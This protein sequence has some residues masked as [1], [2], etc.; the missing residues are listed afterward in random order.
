M[1]HIYDGKSCQQIVIAL[2]PIPTRLCYLVSVPGDS[3]DPLRLNNQ[4]VPEAY[5]FFYGKLFAHR[6]RIL[7]FSLLIQRSSDHSRLYLA[8]RLQVNF[9]AIIKI[10]NTL[11]FISISG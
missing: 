4:K 6:A 8:E 1:N 9:C 11:G 2:R 3:P 7:K 10:V 5:R